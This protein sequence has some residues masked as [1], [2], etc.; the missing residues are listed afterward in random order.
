MHRLLIILLTVWIPSAW[1]ADSVIARFPLDPGRLAGAEIF[2]EAEAHVSEAAQKA[3]LSFASDPRPLPPQVIL[4]LDTPKG[5]V[6]KRHGLLFWRGEMLP[7][8]MAPGDTGVLVRKKQQR[9]GSWKTTRTQQDFEL[10]SRT[11]LLPTARTGAVGT[12][13]AM[14]I[15]TAYH[16]GS[17]GKADAELVLW[18][19]EEEGSEPLAGFIRITHAPSNLVASLQNTL[20]AFEG[21]TNWAVEIDALS[22]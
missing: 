18:R 11:N 8:Q 7:D 4:Q 9:D 10:S 19:T 13:P 5:T 12:L 14:M 6:L 17:A 22:P 15:E 2:T 21:Q 16:L 1:A 3:G 20:P